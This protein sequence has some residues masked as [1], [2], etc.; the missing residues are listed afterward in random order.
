MGREATR[1]KKM[2]TAHLLDNLLCGMSAP[3]IQLYDHAMPTL[4]D[5]LFFTC[6]QHGFNVYG[7]LNG[8]RQDVACIADCPHV[9][10]IPHTAVDD[11]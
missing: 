4:F 1:P 6:I 8:F 3:D 11:N 9:A 2:D 7:Y 10:D 5:K